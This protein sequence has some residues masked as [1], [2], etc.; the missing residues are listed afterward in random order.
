MYQRENNFIPLTVKRSVYIEVILDI[1]HLHEFSLSTILTAINIGDIYVNSKLDNLYPNFPQEIYSS[2]L[3]MVCCVLAAKV[4]ED[5]GY[6]QIIDAV[7]DSENSYVRQ[8]EWNVCSKLEY[9]IPVH[10]FST[11]MSILM[12]KF[13]INISRNLFLAIITH[14]SH[15]T[16]SNPVII[17]FCLLKLHRKGKLNLLSRNINKTTRSNTIS[18]IKESIRNNYDIPI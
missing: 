1:A 17:L 15:L 2:E 8:I 9:T 6:R 13:K 11:L 3:A 12:E 5:K 4:N 14:I 10:N 7:I 18:A 16:T